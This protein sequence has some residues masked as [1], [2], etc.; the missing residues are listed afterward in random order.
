MEEPYEFGKGG[1][2]FYEELWKGLPIRDIF[3][4][5]VHCKIGRQVIALRQLV[6]L[7]QCDQFKSSRLLWTIL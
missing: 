4:F 5:H 1:S 2:G 3:F 6:Q 7:T